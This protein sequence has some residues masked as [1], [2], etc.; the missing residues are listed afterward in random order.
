M[1]SEN[2]TKCDTE[3][4]SPRA[5]PS[6][7]FGRILKRFLTL[8]CEDLHLRIDTEVN[9]INVYVSLTGIFLNYQLII[10]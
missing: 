6:P 2:G 1:Q 9:Q 3:E 7:L 8:C 4:A 5:T 10:I